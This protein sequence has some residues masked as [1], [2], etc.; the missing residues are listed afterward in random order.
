[1]LRKWAKTAWPRAVELPECEIE[2]DRRGLLRGSI[3]AQDVLRLWT[4]DHVERL[5]WSGKF[6]LGRNPATEIH[7]EVRPYEGVIP[8]LARFYNLR[9]DLLPI[10]KAFI[11]RFGDQHD[12]IEIRL[13]KDLSPVPYALVDPYSGKVES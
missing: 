10:R 4:G 9:V 8:G 12:A 3:L 5:C 7:V 6:T 1:M 2:E 11:R 13:G